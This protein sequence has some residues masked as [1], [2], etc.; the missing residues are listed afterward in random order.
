[1]TVTF[2][3]S[4]EEEAALQAQAQTRGLTLQEWVLQLA[5]QSGSAPLELDQISPD[6]TWEQEFDEWLDSFPDTPPLSDE[7]I[8]RVSLYPDR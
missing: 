6:D 2:E 7:A 4:P 5:E 1:M 8:S 3:L